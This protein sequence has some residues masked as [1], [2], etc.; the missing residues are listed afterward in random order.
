[1]IDESRMAPQ[2]GGESEPPPGLQTRIAMAMGAA[3]ARAEKTLERESL[4]VELARRAAAA[5]RAAYLELVDATNLDS[6]GMDVRV[7]TA[8]CQQ[9]H[10]REWNRLLHTPRDEWHR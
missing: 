7:V 8:L 5:A 3:M 6:P 4:G 10:A 2:H 9:Q 1:M